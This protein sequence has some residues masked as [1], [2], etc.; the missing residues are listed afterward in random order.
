MLAAAR[1]SRPRPTRARATGSRGKAATRATTPGW[2]QRWS[3]TT[4][5]TTAT[6]LLIGGVTRPSHGS[7]SRTTTPRRCVLRRGEAPDARRAYR[8]VRR[9]RRWWSCCATWSEHGFTNYIASGGDRDF[10]RADRAGA[11]RHP[12]GRVI[13]SAESSF[14]YAATTT[15]HRARPQGGDATPRRRPAE[16]GPHLEPHRAAADPRRRQ[17]QRRHRRCSSF[18]RHGRRARRCAC[19]SSTTTRSA[20]SPTAGARRRART[21][22]SIVDSRALGWTVVSMRD[23][24]SRSSLTDERRPVWIPGGRRSAWAR[25]RTTP[26]RRRRSAV[27]VDG[28]WIDRAPGH[29]RAS[30]PR[31]ST[32]TGYVTSPSGR[33]T[34][35]TSRARRPRTSCPARSCSRR[36]RGPVDLRH[37]N[38]WWT[39]TPGACWR[40]PEGPGSDARR[41]RR[42]IRSCTSPTR[43]PRPTPRGPGRRCR[44]RREWELAARG[45]LDGAAYAWGDEPEPA[46]RA[47]GQLLARRLPV[48]R[49]ARATGTTAPVGSF[50]P[51]GYG[52]FDM[53]GNVWEWTADWYASRHDDAD[54]PV[55]RPAQP[56]R[57][58]RGELRP[59]AAA[60]RGP[61]Q[62]RQGRLVPV[63][64][65]LLP[66]LPA[67]RA[68]PADDRHRHEPHRLPLRT[69]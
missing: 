65:Q 18:A 4:T 26:R 56:A 15:A 64:R 34:R 69:P 5:A 66:A 9:T 51:N 41:P 17:L 29:Q 6:W 16:A 61:A 10:M 46:G 2:A 28:F 20:S 58:A 42:T 63:R 62:G 53:A 48:A 55:L 43:T 14:E 59:R 24:W 33:S 45:G 68:P 39:W 44:P 31:S 21:P 50:P 60:V 8:D 1:A 49:R 52:L 37:L 54:E 36:T 40:H 57:P 13:G 19:S 22:S 12:A 67:R 27:A 11:L 30:S 23:D 3:S 35:P 32:P 25:T 47:A 7:T 38:Q